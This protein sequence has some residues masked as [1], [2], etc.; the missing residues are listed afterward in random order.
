MFYMLKKLTNE[1]ITQIFGK[2]KRKKTLFKEWE[3]ERNMQ[4]R[5]FTSRGFYKFLT[6]EEQNNARER[7]AD[8]L[9]QGEYEDIFRTYAIYCAKRQQE[10]GIILK[11]E[12]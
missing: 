12:D 10:L 5:F 8:A 4:I 7:A 6:P 2:D 3:K 9:L 1:E 11:E